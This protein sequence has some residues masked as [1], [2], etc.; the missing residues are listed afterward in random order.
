MQNAPSTPSASTGVYIPPHLN[1]NNS[2]A[3]L[4]NGIS[5]EGRYNKDQLMDL[6]KTKRDAG[7]LNRNLSALF[8]GGW[9][10]HEPSQGVSSTWGKRDESKDNTSGPEVCWNHEVDEDPLGLLEMND[11]E[12][13]VR[14]NPVP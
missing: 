6:Y 8:S 13:E 11:Q 5:G 1:T 12:K 10:P 14:C 9:N 3:Y 2:S 7:A 4:R